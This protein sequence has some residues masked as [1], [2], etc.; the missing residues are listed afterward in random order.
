MSRT[1]ASLSRRHLLRTCG[2]ALAGASLLPFAAEAAALSLTPQ[3]IEDLKRVSAYL[4]SI[5]TLQGSFTQI[6][7][8]GD[9]AEGKFYLRRPGKLRFEYLQPAG[10]PIIV[11]DG[12]WVLVEDRSLKTTARYPLNATPLSILLRDNIDLVS[13]KTIVDVRRE[14]GSLSVTARDDKGVAQGELQLIFSDPALELRNWII[15]DA[16]GYFTTVSV[17]DLKEGVTID[18]ALFTVKDYTRRGPGLR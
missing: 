6:A 2:L 13:E 4:N 16:Q 3:D 1:L 14:L 17:R 7:Q 8:N 11:A 9:M 18:P 5:V 15:K 12:T 10:M